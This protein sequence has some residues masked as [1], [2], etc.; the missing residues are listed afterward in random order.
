MLLPKNGRD[1]EVGSF[2]LGVLGPIRSSGMHDLAFCIHSSVC[3]DFSASKKSPTSDSLPKWGALCQITA[4]VSSWREGVL[5]T[6]IARGP[7][8][9]RTR[10]RSAPIRGSSM[11]GGRRCCGSPAWLPPNQAAAGAGASK[12]RNDRMTAFQ[13]AWRRGQRYML[14]T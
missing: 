9:G 4:G 13:D 10:W 1:F 7:F 3:V 12:Q 8:F 6:G 14:T 2:W 5:S 11:E